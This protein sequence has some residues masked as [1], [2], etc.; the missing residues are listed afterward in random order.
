MEY[1]EFEDKIGKRVALKTQENEDFTGVLTNTKSMLETQS[2]EDEIILDTGKLYICI[3]FSDI[4]DIIEIKILGLRTQESEGFNNFFKIV[5]DSA[6]QRN[7]IFFLYN[8]VG[9]YKVIDNMECHNLSGWLIEEYM[10][11]EFIY[12]Y[13]SYNELKDW[14]DDMLTVEWNEIDGEVDIE[15]NKCILIKDDRI[16]TRE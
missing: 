16:I 14:D 12:D 9:N 3:P 6:K 7:C 13:M 1:K 5:Q 2:G 10:S 4:K 15:F 8:T 11:D